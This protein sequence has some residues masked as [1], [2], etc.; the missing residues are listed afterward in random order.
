MAP[1]AQPRYRERLWPSFGVWFLA[2]FVLLMCDVA[3][4]AALGWTYGLAFSILSGAGV[5]FWLLNL[6]A[7]VE[8]DDHELRAGRAHIELRY[9]T[10][11]TEL[12]AEQAR[13]AMGRDADARTYLVTRGWIR[14]AVQFRLT[15]DA[16]PT[17]GW[18]VST[19]H[20]AELAAELQHTQGVVPGLSG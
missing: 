14:T 10:D 12:D 16:D 7:R 4:W 9:V 8:V 18:I 19:R 13:L 6:S 3:V 2:F 5:L 15:D 11:V 1:A 17:P 20:P